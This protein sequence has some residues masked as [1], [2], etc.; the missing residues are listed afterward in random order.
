MSDQ[1]IKGRAAD[2]V[3]TAEDTVTGKKLEVLLQFLTLTGAP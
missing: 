1:V 3:R 2:R